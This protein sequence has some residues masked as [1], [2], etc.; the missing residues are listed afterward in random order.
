MVQTVHDMPRK[1][2][3]NVVKGAAEEREDEDKNVTTSGAAEYVIFWHTEG[4]RFS[5]AL[6]FT[7]FYI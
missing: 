3:R 2:K 4:V 6:K 7:N 1:T 5:R